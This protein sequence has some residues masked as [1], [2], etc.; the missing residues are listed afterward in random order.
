[1]GIWALSSSFRKGRLHY[2]LHMGG[3]PAQGMCWGENTSSQTAVQWQGLR[4]AR[5][6]ES[7]WKCLL[8][9]KVIPAMFP[10][11]SSLNFGLSVSWGREL[12][13]KEL[14]HLVLPALHE[15]E[16]Q[17]QLTLLIL[18][19]FYFK[20]LFLKN[21]SLQ[22]IASVSWLCNFVWY[23]IL[24]ADSF[25]NSSSALPRIDE[26]LCCHCGPLHVLKGN[27]QSLTLLFNI[28]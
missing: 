28:C 8:Y 1:M 11:L 2:S 3:L 4:G 12:C 26:H 24:H 6:W 7:G 27:L 23:L 21:W 16:L 5:Y 10:C 14:S 13:I 19:S 17:S 18:S 25:I 22:N 9:C 15:S 20:R